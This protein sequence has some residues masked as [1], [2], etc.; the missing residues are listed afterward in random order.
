MG[1]GRL[2]CPQSME[3]HTKLGVLQH[4]HPSGARSEPRKPTEKH[5]GLHDREWFNESRHKPKNATS[6]PQRPR[7]VLFIHYLAGFWPGVLMG[8]LAGLTVG[9]LIS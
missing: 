4:P 7:R 2:K 9:L 1:Q 6:A 5:M 3:V 8:F